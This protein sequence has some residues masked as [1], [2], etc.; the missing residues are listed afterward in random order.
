MPENM[1]VA[2]YYANDDVRIE[3]TARPEAG[4]GEAVMRVMASGIC[5]SDIMQW[6]RRDKV[7]LVLGHEVAG[8]IVQTGPGVESI[9]PGDRVVAAHH[10]PCNT[11]HYCLDRHH[12]VCNTLRTTNFHPGGMSEY[13]LLPP[14]NVEQG[15]FPMPD[16]MSF[17]EG[18]FVEPLACVLRGQRAARVSKGKSV[19][20][21][22]SGI[23][24]A[25]H[26]SLSRAIGAELVVST[27]ISAYRLAMAE[28]AGAHKALMAN[29]D[30]AGAFRKLNKGRGADAV[31]LTA[32][33][34][35]A[36]EQAFRSIDRGGSI[37]FFA[38]ANEGAEIKLPVNE[39]FWKNE[40][41]LTSSYA[42][43]HGDHTEAIELI[44]SG[45]VDVK[46][47]ITHT[48]PLSRAQEGFRLVASG[49]ESLKVILKPN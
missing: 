48:L 1:K 46:P 21:I 11:C 38:P 41:T 47:M 19:L 4:P 18:T 45:R 42:A 32:G 2:M 16:G 7:P 9:K 44:A 27:D 40:I 8:E 14:I 17:E 30:V 6:Y 43:D 29:S 10:V 3:E 39:L 22:G 36:I 13:L 5:G 28:K 12:T 31:I 49:G 37:L 26:I 33:A 15:V 34:P 20:I 23:S 35:E 24:G 25:L